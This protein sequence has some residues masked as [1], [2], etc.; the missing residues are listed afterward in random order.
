M[1]GVTM[2]HEVTGMTSFEIEGETSKK[3][4]MMGEPIIVGVLHV[5]VLQSGSVKTLN[6]PEDADRDFEL[7]S[8]DEKTRTIVVRRKKS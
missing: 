7:V 6:L 2:M 8:V 3:I 5:D 1:D 4:E